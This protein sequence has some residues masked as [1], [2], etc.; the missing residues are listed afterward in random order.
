MKTT[1]PLKFRVWH[2]LREK[3]FDVVQI[4]DG[5]PAIVSHASD[6]GERTVTQIMTKAD[7]QYLVVVQAT[8]YK[9]AGN[10][11]IYEGDILTADD[12]PL[13]DRM[14]V[15]EFFDGS[16]IVIYTDPDEAGDEGGMLSE[17]AEAGKLKVIGSALEWLKDQREEEGA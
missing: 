16:F 3:M 12:G 2:S 17:I 8:G 13:K 10:R 6:V 11:D 7:S 14:G 4:H 15:V 1:L 5:I 9:A